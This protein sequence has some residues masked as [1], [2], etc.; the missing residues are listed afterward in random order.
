MWLVIAKMVSLRTKYLLSSFYSYKIAFIFF[1]V[2]L[3]YLWGAF[4]DVYEHPKVTGVSKLVIDEWFFVVIN[5]SSFTETYIIPF[6]LFIT[7]LFVLAI[8]YF[9]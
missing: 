2:P 1:N 7:N 4:E 3:K 6:V 5:G 9:L 8:R